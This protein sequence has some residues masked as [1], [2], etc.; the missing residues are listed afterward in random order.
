MKPPRNPQP[1]HDPY[2]MDQADRVLLRVL[3]GLALVGLA[4]LAIHYL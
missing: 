2:G 3:V 4:R 1:W